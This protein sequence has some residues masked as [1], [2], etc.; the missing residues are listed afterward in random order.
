M[1]TKRYWYRNLLEVWDSTRNGNIIVNHACTRISG[2]K[3]PFEGNSTFCPRGCPVS[4]L[5]RS[6][7]ISSHASML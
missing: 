1:C 5:S 6:I 4:R 2:A 3:A 7:I